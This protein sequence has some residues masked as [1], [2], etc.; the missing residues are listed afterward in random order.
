MSDPNF[1]Q[2]TGLWNSK[3]YPKFLAKGTLQISLKTP[4]DKP[5]QYDTKVVIEYLGG[6]GLFKAGSKDHIP[7]HVDVAPTQIKSDQLDFNMK[8]NFKNLKI[9]YN[10]DKFSPTRI[11]GTYSVTGTVNDN[12]VFWMQPKKNN[13]RQQNNG[14]FGGFM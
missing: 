5:Q 1:E 14:I 4:Y 9:S 10:I 11:S 13:Q 12:G 8:G 2:W 7:L 3:K 6:Y